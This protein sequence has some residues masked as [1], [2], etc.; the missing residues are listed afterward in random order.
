MGDRFNAL[1][2]CTQRLQL[3]HHWRRRRALAI[4]DV[5]VETDV[6]QS[7]LNKPTWYEQITKKRN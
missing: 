3:G 2:G 7:P 4:P 1:A 6:T 5:T